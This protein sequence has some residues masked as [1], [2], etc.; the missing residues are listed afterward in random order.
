[1][2]EARLFIGGEEIESGRW[3][4]VQNPARPAEIVGRVAL[5]D[6]SQAVDAVDA[7]ADAFPSWSATPIDKRVELIAAAA[8]RAAADATE[9]PSLLTREQG[10]VLR[11]A[12]MEVGMF[13]MHLTSYARFAAEIDKVTKFDDP[14][15]GSLVRRSRPRGP[16]VVISP[17]NWPV[18]QLGP[19]VGAQLMAGNTITVKPP[20]EAPLAVYET[21]KAVAASLPPGVLNVVTG[22][23][24]EIGSALLTHPK[25]RQIS[26]TG[27][28]TSGRQVMA[29]AASHVVNT[30]LE[31]GGNDPAIVLADAE[32]DGAA[33]T[34]MLQSTFTTTG[35]GCQLVKRVYVHRSRHDELVELLQAGIDKF[36][37]VGDGLEKETTMGPLCTERQRDFVRD[38]V[39]DARDRGAT[40]LE[41]GT[42]KDPDLVAGG[43]FHMPTLIVDVPADARVVREEQFGPVLPIVAFDDDDEALALANDTEYGLA[44]S[45]WSGD[46]DRAWQLASSIDAGTVMVNHHNVFVIGGDAPQTGWKQSGLGPELGLDGV[47]ALMETSVITDRTR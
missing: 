1:M 24:S 28:T 16:A 31:L 30:V 41:C 6:A 45:V 12:K 36:Y 27:G 13:G 38:L 7:S 9:R 39:V 22:E 3:A 26:F 21:L 46:R 42:T 4:E 47:L 37:V 29:Q 35:Q 25:V 14:E 2:N 43:W 19:K 5:A 8:E 15:R 11:E 33:I 18:A 40:V 23:V 34:R 10:K 20:L 44:A 17:W 32:L